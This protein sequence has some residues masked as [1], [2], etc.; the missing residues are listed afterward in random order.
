LRGTEAPATQSKPSTRRG[1]WIGAGVASTIAIVAMV[2][3]TLGRRTTTQPTGLAQQAP[4]ASIGLDAIA[5]QPVASVAP[6]PVVSA[7][8]NQPD[9]TPAPAGPDP[10]TPSAKAPAKSNTTA[11]SAPPAARSSAPVPAATTKKPAD[12]FDDITRQ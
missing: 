5:P 4:N 2:G 12:G 6:E 9:A 11:E 10:R 7:S 8:A 3:W 1:L